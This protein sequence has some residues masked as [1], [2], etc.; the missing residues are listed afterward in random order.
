MVG[1]SVVAAVDIDLGFVSVVDESSN[2]FDFSVVPWDFHELM[3]VLYCLSCKGIV[4][5]S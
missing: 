3:S 4:F 2:V 1:Q 5:N